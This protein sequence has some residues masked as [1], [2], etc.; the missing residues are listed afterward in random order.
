[1]TNAP[2]RPF[3]TVKWA[4]TLD[5]R[6][7]ATD[8]SSQWITGPD[9]R[10]DVHR[11]RAAADAILVGT[12]TVLADNPSLTARAR[13]GELLVAAEEQ[14]FPVVVGHREIPRGA[15][16]LDHPRLGY[17]L[18]TL[19]APAAEPLRLRGDDLAADMGRLYEL[20][21]RTVFVEGGPTIVSSLIRTGLVD[22]LLV[23]IAPALLGGPRLATGDIGAPS[24]SDIVRLHLTET[25]QLGTDLLIRATPAAPK[26]E[27]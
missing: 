10:A 14:P 19:G 11:R 17:P 23:Y 1:M 15:K 21:I 2:S 16:L 18:G 27:R 8:G 13:G 9:A 24:M 5:G 26:E 22:E 20:G 3:I 4:Q 6:A 7:A 12:G 25:L